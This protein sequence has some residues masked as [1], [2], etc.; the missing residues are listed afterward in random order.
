MSADAVMVRLFWWKP[1]D[2][3]VFHAVAQK[4]SFG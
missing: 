1:N 4:S 2:F 3:G